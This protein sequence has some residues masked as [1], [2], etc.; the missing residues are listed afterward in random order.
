MMLEHFFKVFVV[1]VCWKLRD[2]LEVVIEAPNSTMSSAVFLSRQGPSGLSL[3]FFF[4]QKKFFLFK[5]VLQDRNSRAFYVT[6]EIVFGEVT[7]HF[8]CP[9]SFQDF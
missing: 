9:N 1:C 8:S 4:F 2:C 5:V 7:G 6:Q 3:Y